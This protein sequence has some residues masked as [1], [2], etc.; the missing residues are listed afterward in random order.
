M[1]T[2]RAKPRHQWQRELAVWLL[3]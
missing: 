1:S 2:Q 3:S